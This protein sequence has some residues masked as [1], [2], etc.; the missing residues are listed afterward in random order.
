M[1]TDIVT[2]ALDKA[3]RARESEHFTDAGN[4]Q[5][6]VSAHG[7]KIRFLFEHK[8]WLAWDGKRWAPDATGAVERYAKDTVRLMYRD[9][10][11]IEDDDTRT[12][13]VKWA[14]ASESAARLDAM[15]RLARSDERIVVRA[16]DLDADSWS[17]NVANGT[18]DL[19]TGA[20]RPH[21][22]AEM[23]SKIADAAMPD[24]E[25]PAGR[26]DAFL[27]EVLPDPEVRRFVQKLVGYSLTGEVGEN[28]L[29]FPYGSGANGKSVFLGVLR[30]ILGDYATEAAPDLLV[31]RRERGIPVDV[32]DL[33]GYRFVTTTEV[34]GGRRMAT[35]V[36]KRITGEPRLKARRMRQDFESFRNVTTLWMAA[37]DRPQVDGLDEAIWRRVRLIPFT[38]TIAPDKRD[39]FLAHTLLKER[40]A[41]LRWAVQGCLAWQDEG[42]TPPDAVMSATD[43]YRDE[44]NPI[45][46]WIESECELDP[47]AVTAGSD[48]R[49]SYERWATVTRSRKV[50]NGAKWTAALG[51]LGVHRPTDADEQGR[52]YRNGRLAREWQGI[53][54]RKGGGFDV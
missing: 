16:D 37:N 49:G 45:A 52:V 42:L 32:A 10:A 27:L 11:R 39:P 31:A 34:E 30:E 14:M 20:L 48:L 38:V 9:A 40:N 7:G 29:P 46:E 54:V 33:R 3:A 17:L 28:V 12:K 19:R 15:M 47:D 1:S 35:D 25:T 36:M 43:E 5:R 6:L 50:P 21:D 2:Q 18:V 44:S 41:I 4:A 24:A 51:S 53:R 13:A 23:H 8:R 22:S 26:W